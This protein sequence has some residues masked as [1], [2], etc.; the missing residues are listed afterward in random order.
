MRNILFACPKS[1][2]RTKGGRLSSFGLLPHIKGVADV[3]EVCALTTAEAPGALWQGGNY[4]EYLR[5]HLSDDFWLRKS[6]IRHKVTKDIPSDVVAVGN[7][8]KILRD[9]NEHDREYDFKDKKF[10]SSL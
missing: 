8:C 7:P 5:G 2:K 6:T 1:T 10:R 3:H 4:R 9:I